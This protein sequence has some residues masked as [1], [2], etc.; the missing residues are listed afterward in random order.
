[1]RLQLKLALS[2]LLALGVLLR[3]AS[4]WAQSAVKY[5]RL[6]YDETQPGITVDED[7]LEVQLQFENEDRFHFDLTHDVVTGASPTGLP[8]NNTTTG[9]SAAAGKAG[10]GQ[11]FAKFQD[12][13]WAADIGYA[14][15]LSRTLRLDTTLHFSTERDYRS[16]GIT[17]APTFE[18]N[19][20]NTVVTPSITLYRDRVLPSNSTPDADKRTV[21]YA[22]DASQILNPRNVVSLGLALNASEGYLTDPYKRVPVGTAAVDETRPDRRS[23]GSLQ[24]GLRTKPWDHHALDF[25]LR[26]YRDDWD[27][28]SW[29]GNASLLSELGEKWLLEWFGRYY[30]QS[31]AYFW[32]ST[33]AAGDS[34]KYR[35]ADPRLSTFD[36]TTLGLTGTFKATEHWWFELSFAQYLQL[37]STGGK[38]GE[39]GH[40]EG[41]EAEGRDSASTA[42][43]RML[44]GEDSEGGSG[45]KPFLKATVVSAAAQYR[46]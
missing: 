41:G 4:A 10:Q 14:P 45:K 29:T 20:K 43:P 22:L 1:M 37:T 46:W 28:R 31:K 30:Q 21:V 36:S 44:V 33:Y 39:A 27:I 15:L 19:K 3:T 11:Q 38:G 6:R 7:T 9:A 17:L 34:S 18:L 42:A 2:L 13:R 24:V 5:K 26:Y 35:S 40:G 8:Q 16:T 32:Q 12:E 23:G 25:K